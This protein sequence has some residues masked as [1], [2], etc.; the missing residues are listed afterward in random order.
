MSSI[1]QTRARTTLS[2]GLLDQVVASGATFVFIVIAATNVSARELGAIAFVFELYLLSVFV[3]RGMTGDPLTS[4]SSGADEA[5]LR[6]AVR[7]STTTVLFIGT[8]IGLLL[9]VAATFADSPMRGVLVVAAFA[10]PLLTLQ[11]FVRAALIVQGR[12]RATFVND[13]VWAVGQVPAMGVAIAINP[14]AVTLFSAWAAT[15]CVAALVGLVQLRCGIARPRA[16]RE[17]LRETK[18]LWPYYLADNLV[19]QATSLLFTIVV[20]ATAGLAAMAGFRVAMTVYA[21]LSL[22]GRG[23]ITVSVSMLARIRDNPAEVRRRAMLISAVLTPLAIGWGLLTLLV[24]TSAGKK[25]F[26]ESWLEAEPVVFLACFVCASGLFA[27]GVVVGLRALSAG[28]HTLAGRLTVSVGAATAAAVG[29]VL[30]EQQGIFLGLAMFFPVQVLVWWLLLNDATRR[31]E[32][33]LEVRAERQANDS[34]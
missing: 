20:S 6:I 24:P 4:R 19:F 25:L 17:W 13:M 26:G 28:R 3:A 7:S 14:T 12:G 1:P 11:D 33:A 10:L 18:N 15:G 8:G 30:G 16:V 27:T 21:P 32:R 2:W 29:G 31:A 5:S 9:A 23:L 34:T 22:I